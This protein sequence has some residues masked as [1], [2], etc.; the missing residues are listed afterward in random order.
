MVTEQ[1]QSDALQSGDSQLVV[2]GTGTSIGVPVVGCDC[3]VCQ[4]DD[5][6]NHRLRSGI[7]VRAPEGEFVIDTGPE[8][9]LQLLQNKAT[10]IQAALFTHAHADHIMGL[11]DLRIFGFR[12]ERMALQAAEEQALKDG[13]K[14]D[15]DAAAKDNPGNIPLYCEQ[16]VEDGIRQ[17]FHY[18]F[19]DPNSHS[20]RY[21]APRLGFERIQPNQSLN[22]LGLEVLPIRLHHGKLPILGFR[23]GNVA[24]CTDVST[25]P[26]D[27]RKLLEGLDVLILDALR[28]QPHPTHLSVSQAVK[29]AERLKPKQTYLT[30]MSHDLDY[31]QLIQ[32]LPDGIAP[33][34]D[35]L[36]IPIAATSG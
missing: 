32:E 34:Y 2:M 9:R 25:I 24:F 3:D 7:L 30:H 27:S 14:F 33:A 23:I 13:I 17:V 8:L 5:S 28:Y 19:T 4:S 26:A 16:L 29:W 31:H 20:H 36:T 22:V 12:K 35:G 18:A 15:A 11:D 21:A 1:I 6:K 10:F